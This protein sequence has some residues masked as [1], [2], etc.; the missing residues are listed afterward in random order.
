MSTIGDHLEDKSIES[1]GDCLLPT[2]FPHRVDHRV[3]T[4]FGTRT[5]CPIKFTA[6]EYSNVLMN[7][8]LTCC[9]SPTS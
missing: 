5:W 6:K 3:L 8:A 2:S 4:S 1:V 9:I 7:A